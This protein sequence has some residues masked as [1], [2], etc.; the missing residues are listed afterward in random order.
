MSLRRPLESECQ[1]TGFSHE[2]LFSLQDAR[3]LRIQVGSTVW[4]RGTM[5]VWKDGTLELFPARQRAGKADLLLGSARALKRELM[6][7]RGRGQLLL[8]DAGKR[9]R[10]VR[11]FKQP[12]WL[13]ANELVAFDPTVSVQVNLLQSL[14]SWVASPQVRVELRG[15]GMLAL[16]VPLEWEEVSAGMPHGVRTPHPVPSVAW[17]QGGGISRQGSWSGV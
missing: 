2:N 14:S 12:L 17:S 15:E 4:I 7:V 8:A 13:N 11:L 10:L 6:Q 16:S 1:D 3:T 9:I 5:L